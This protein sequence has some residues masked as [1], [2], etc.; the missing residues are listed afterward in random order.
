MVYISPLMQ[1]AQGAKLAH[2]NVRTDAMLSAEG[3]GRIRATDREAHRAQHRQRQFR[4]NLQT[5][6]RIEPG[7]PRTLIDVSGC[8]VLRHDAQLAAREPAPPEYPW[9][10]AYGR[11]RYMY[12]SS[13]RRSRQK[14]PDRYATSAST[15]A[16]Q[17]TAQWHREYA[18]PD[19]RCRRRR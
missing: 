11:A 7:L 10:S 17:P 12:S 3:A 6:R 16:T 15:F 5:A 18:Q 8:E 2:L 19:I 13:P 14:P 4:A 1:L 9:R